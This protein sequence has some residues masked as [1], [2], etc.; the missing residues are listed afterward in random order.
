MNRKDLLKEIGDVMETYGTFL[1]KDI[2][3][4]DL[5]I[6][7]TSTREIRVDN[8]MFYGVYVKE[9]EVGT[10]KYLSKGYHSYEILSVDT[11]T[12]IFFLAD[13]YR[14]TKIK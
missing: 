3:E 1:L 8:L 2:N 5:L 13:L 11:L 6:G 10:G 14:N 9:Y 7:G 12:Q 4:E